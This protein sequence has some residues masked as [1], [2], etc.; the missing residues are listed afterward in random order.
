MNNKFIVNTPINITT[1]NRTKIKNLIK[2]LEAINAIDE[3]I[4]ELIIAEAEC[5]DYLEK[6]EL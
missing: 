2:S 6:H 4:A 5:L 1:E 3:Y